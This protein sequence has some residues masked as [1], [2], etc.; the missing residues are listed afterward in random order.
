[1]VKRTLRES[2]V[3]D[4]VIYESGEHDFPKEVEAALRERGAFGDE[5]LAQEAFVED[6]LA[7]AVDTAPEVREQAEKDA[8]PAR[9]E[10]IQAEAEQAQANAD[11]LKRAARGR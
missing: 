11:A 3:Y 7:A 2:Y 8:A 1:M 5:P 9:R 6:R 10:V 4:G